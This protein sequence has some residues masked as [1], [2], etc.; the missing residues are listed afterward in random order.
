[1]RAIVMLM[2]CCLLSACGGDSGGV[3]GDC[4]F[5]DPDTQLC[6][7]QP[8][9]DEPMTWQDAIAYCDDLVH[10]GHADWRLPRIQELITLVRGCSSIDCQVHDPDCLATSCRQNP[11]C[12]GCTQD[13]GPAENGCYWDVALTGT[14]DWYHSSS[15]VDGGPYD[16]WYIYFQSGS[17]DNGAM[18]L[19]KQVR[20]V[21]TQAE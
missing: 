12:Q 15:A 4:P 5:L 10:A 17:V 1:M 20:C 11:E 6:W 7:Q 3:Q 21:T 13:E 19:E 9:A 18:G 16:A 2:P 14:C 8:P